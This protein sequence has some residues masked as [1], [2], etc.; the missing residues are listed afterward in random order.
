M[1]SI[2]IVRNQELV[3]ASH[4]RIARHFR[5]ELFDGGLGY[6]PAVLLGAGRVTHW[7]SHEVAAIAD[8]LAEERDAPVRPLDRDRRF[9][10]LPRDRDA[11]ADRE[12]RNR[13]PAAIRV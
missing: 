4:V 5:A 7:A 8:E 9:G 10:H 3:P 13:A 11:I 12:L 2:A 6:A 1:P